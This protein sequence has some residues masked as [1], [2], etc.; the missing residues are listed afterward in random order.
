MNRNDYQLTGV[1]HV[2]K[3]RTEALEDLASQDRFATFDALTPDE[4]I[5]AWLV[6]KRL[7]AGLLHIL[8]AP[9]HETPSRPGIYISEM[10]VK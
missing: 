6:T 4:P 5:W 10:A 7:L 9:R 1:I 8:T 2:Q 3:L